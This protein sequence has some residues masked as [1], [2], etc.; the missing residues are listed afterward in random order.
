MLDHLG[1]AARVG[2][3]QVYGNPIGC[4]AR[5]CQKAGGALVASG[6]LSRAHLGVDA[7]AYERMDEGERPGGIEDRHLGERVGGVGG[8]VVVEVGELCCECRFGTLS[9]HGHSASEGDAAGWQPS[10]AG[11][12]RSADAVRA[13]LA[14]QAGVLATRRDSSPRELAE[15][16]QEQERIAAGG[17]LAGGDECSDR[18]QRP[19]TVMRAS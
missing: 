8:F 5:S 11:A 6:T 9:E 7:R 4:F 10:Q 14:G 18:G 13:Q 3:Q 12:H 1:I 2:R 17:Q 19:G 15:E 16:L